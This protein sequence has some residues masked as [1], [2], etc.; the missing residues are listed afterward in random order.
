MAEIEKFNHGLSHD[1][2]NEYCKQ[3]WEWADQYAYDVVT[4]AKL[5]P[6]NII[7][8]CQRYINDRESD[9]WFFSTNKANRVIW[10]CN[11]QKH[12]TGDLAGT[13]FMLEPWQIFIYVN[14]FA[15]LHKEP[16]KTAGKRVRRF[17]TAD[18]YIPRK[19]GK[20]F[21]CSTIANYLLTM[22]GEQGAQVVTAGK[23]RNQAK[24]CREDA[25][26]ML[27]ATPFSRLAKFTRDE[28]RIPST[29]SRLYSISRDSKSA[30]GK[31]PNGAICDELHTHPNNE[32]Y[33]VIYRGMQARSQ[34]LLIGIST[35]GANM[36][37]L[38]MD[39]WRYSEA[40]LDQVIDDDSHFALLYGIDKDDDWSDEQNWIKANPNMFVS[41]SLVNM[42]DEFKKSQF[43]TKDRH[44]FVLKQLNFWVE[45]AQ[46]WLEVDKVNS[47]I[48]P[49]LNIEN[50]T[51]R[52]CYIGCDIAKNNDLSALTFLFPNDDGTFTAF[53]KS[54]TPKESMKDYPSD[55][56]TLFKGFH[57][58]GYLTL[59]DGNTTD[60]DAIASDIKEAH[61]KFNVKAFSYDT[62]GSRELEKLLSNMQQTLV[63]VSQGKAKM[64][65]PSQYFERL[66]LKN[67]IKFEDNP[68]F[69]WQCLNAIAEVDENENLKIKK[70][71]N[72]SPRKIDNVI[73]TIIALAV[74]EQ[75]QTSIYEERGIMVF[76]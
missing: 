23:D 63:E 74:A 67:E 41:K 20:S 10:F 8:A 76:G 51:G 17:K 6:L 1:A 47:C 45:C 44:D 42:C 58:D 34:P 36:N 2:G 27:K 32:V 38:G 11:I 25:A 4:G 26:T 60:F 40:V 14:L 15:F 16:H 61:D 55:I 59:T 50:F 29:N 9:K 3:S 75:K 13:N 64:S 28:I 49:A 35:C 68:L 31:N 33:N 56:E 54:Y 73:S 19:N 70:E 52:D 12:V 65:E 37:G 62:W 22:D 7:K 53:F 30:E 5:A 66:I 43:N 18:I 48:D 69:K 21:L 72:S 71:S 57:S 46:S 39:R 24:I